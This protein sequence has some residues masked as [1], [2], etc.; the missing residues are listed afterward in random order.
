MGH[1]SVTTTEIS[2]KYILRRLEMDFPSLVRGVKNS[3]KLEVGHGNYGHKG[4]VNPL[5]VGIIRT[6][7]LK[8]SKGVHT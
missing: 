4:D 7:N 8:C 3:Q 6:Y 2:A 1:S 5:N